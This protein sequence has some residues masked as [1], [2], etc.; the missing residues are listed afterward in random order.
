MERTERKNEEEEQVTET[1][2]GKEK[3]EA[4]EYAKG[5]WESCWACVA[6]RDGSQQAQVSVKQRAA[7]TQ[8][9]RR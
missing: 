8:A 3:E 2:T 4:T 1:E 7:Q 5:S 9:R 6:L